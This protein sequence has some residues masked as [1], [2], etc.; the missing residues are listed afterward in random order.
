MPKEDHFRFT[1]G[2]HPQRQSEESWRRKRR[3]DDDDALTLV[4][5]RGQA[6]G[7]EKFPITVGF[8]ESLNQS[9]VKF[10]CEPSI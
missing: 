6:A 10:L 9:D 4:Q 3:S 5:E 8:Q 1:Q 2:A 7:W